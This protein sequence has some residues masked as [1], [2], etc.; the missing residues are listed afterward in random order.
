VTNACVTS[1]IPRRLPPRGAAG[2]YDGMRRCPFARLSPGG[3]RPKGSLGAPPR[4]LTQEP[5]P[6]TFFEAMDF[7]RSHGLFPKS[8]TFSE[9]LDFFLSH[10]LFSI[11][12]PR[13]E[14]P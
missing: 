11:N 8:R 4:C 12:Q 9:A 7:F 1:L 13:K 6:G 3:S 10:G 2:R 14:T 5:T